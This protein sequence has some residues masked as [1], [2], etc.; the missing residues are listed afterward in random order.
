MNKMQKSDPVITY[1]HMQED[2]TE[3]NT[4]KSFSNFKIKNKVA[5]IFIAEEILIA[6]LLGLIFYMI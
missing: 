3:K 1:N 5:L 4:T 2:T 6:L